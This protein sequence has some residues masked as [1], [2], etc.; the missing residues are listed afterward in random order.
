MLLGKSSWQNSAVRRVAFV[1]FLSAGAAYQCR[2]DIG[3]LPGAFLRF[4]V[5]ARA[6][7]MGGAQ[8]ASPGD[9]CTWWDPAMLST[10]RNTQ[11][12]LGG[13]LMSLG[14]AE[15][16]SS[17][18]FKISPRVGMG[19]MPLYRGDPSLDNLYNENEELLSSGSYSTLTVKV[20]LSYLATRKLSL[21]LAIG[22]YYEQLP[23][24]YNNNNTLN[25][26]SATAVGGFDFALRYLPL[27]NWS[28]AV[29][30][31]NIDLLKILSGNKPGIDLNWEVGSS[32]NINASII[33]R[34]VP[35]VTAASSVDMKLDGRPFIW[36]C[37]IDAYAID[38]DF[39]KLDHMEIRL[40][41]GF[42]WKRWDVFAI[43]AGLGDVLLNRTVFSSSNGLD[44]RVTLGFGVDLSR[45]HKGLVLN[46]AIATDRVW[47]G[48][49]QKTDL[50]FRF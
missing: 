43:R 13:G 39:N 1:L 8:T 23:T 22:Y 35:T 28:C 37:D 33:E 24:S 27:A 32:D 49:D 15:G 4:P 31:R 46:Y 26:S 50:T 3:G 19:F 30:V 9:L 18:E 20:A 44:P 6:L 10:K 14:R 7:A 47:A 45:V 48:V 21:G 2:A 12:A 34:I 11:V 5:G 29:V 25:Y 41:N 16:Y 42:E 17:I 40:N 36:A 38:G